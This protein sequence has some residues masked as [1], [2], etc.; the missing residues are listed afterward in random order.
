MIESGKDITRRVRRAILAVGKDQVANVCM[1]TS[2][3]HKD[4]GQLF[5]ASA[6]GLQAGMVSVERDGDLSDALERRLAIVEAAE[7]ALRHFEL[8]ALYGAEVE[9]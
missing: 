4:I 3:L 6:M 9:R 8:A 2:Q 7:S 5:V 1:H